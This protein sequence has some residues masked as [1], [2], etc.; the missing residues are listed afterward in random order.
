M[1]DLLSIFNKL[2]QDTI[3]DYYQALYWYCSNNHSGQFTQLYSILSTLSYKPSLSETADSVNWE[4]LDISI[5]E[6]NMLLLATALCLYAVL[7]LEVSDDE[8]RKFAKLHYVEALDIYLAEYHD[9][10]EVGFETYFL[11]YSVS[12]AGTICNDTLPY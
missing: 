2:S 7:E 5:T 11:V 3:F 10:H 1:S 8:D 4:T 6:E 12:S 9:H